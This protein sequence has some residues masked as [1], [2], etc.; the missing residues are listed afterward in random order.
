MYE[1]LPDVD[2]HVLQLAPGG[3]LGRFI[4][5]TKSAFDQLDSVFGTVETESKEKKGYRL[6]QA[7]MTNS[8]LTRLINSDEIQSIVRPKKTVCIML[9]PYGCMR[10]LKECIPCLIQCAFTLMR[11]YQGRTNLGPVQILLAPFMILYR[12]VNDMGC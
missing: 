8:D 4:I 9:L 5:W 6:P 3:H 7:P 12:C 10:M 11:L 1:A 2:L